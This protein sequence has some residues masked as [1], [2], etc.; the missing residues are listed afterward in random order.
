[1]KILITGGTGFIG[2]QLAK[3][4]TNKG[5][6]VDL[7]DLYEPSRHDTEFASL[8]NSELVR[9]FKLD[10]MNNEELSKLEKNYTIIVHLA[11]LLGVQNVIDSP[12]KTL[13]A[14]VQMT[15]NILKF[16]RQNPKLK[17]FL[18]ASTSEVY[19]GTLRNGT[20][21]IP[22]PENTTLILPPLHEPRTS[23]MLSKIYGEALCAQSRLPYTII[24]PHNVYGPRMGN[25]H[26]IPQL[27][28]KACET[29]E[30]YLEVF[31][32]EHTR[33]FCFITDAVEM[34]VELLATPNSVGK[35]FNIGTEKPEVPI[36]EVAQ[37]IIDQI[38]KPLTI[39]PMPATEGSPERRAPDMSACF[40]VT[41]FSSKVSLE[42]G[43]AK[44]LEWYAPTFRCDS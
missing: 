38:G 21:R 28:K 17:K 18:F 22:T 13:D 25:R 24:R 23:Y 19:A 27:L 32:V 34:I 11:A 42:Q 43:I 29:K 15:T 14:N 16:G 30:S 6:E 37:I 5:V 12:D 26:V 2:C 4:L 31:S 3:A 40:A 9:F 10:L 35:T 20:L 36:K 44:C 8:M 39:K 7:L 1:M 41:N 33:T